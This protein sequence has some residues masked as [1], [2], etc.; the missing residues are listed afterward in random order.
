MPTRS[1]CI[2]GVVDRKV[3]V[4]MK[5]DDEIARVMLANIDKDDLVDEPLSDQTIMLRGNGAVGGK[6]YEV[7]FNEAITFLE[8][9]AGKTL[10]LYAEE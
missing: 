8:D 7:S 2:S 6:E 4:K 5:N 9:S 3:D 10:E 1:S